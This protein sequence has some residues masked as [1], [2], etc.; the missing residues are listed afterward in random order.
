VEEKGREQENVNRHEKELNVMR[1]DEFER[2]RDVALDI[3][4]KT[5]MWRYRYRPPLLVL[6][7][8]IGVK[9]PPFLLAD[10]GIIII[11]Q[12]VPMSII[13]GL[14]YI[15]VSI[16]TGF[17]PLIL[18]LVLMTCFLYWI[19]GTIFVLLENAYLRQKYK[20]P[21]WSEL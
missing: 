7:W 12:T 3:L 16:I 21:R 19:I 18:S 11:Y 5:G 14:S 15:L 13:F 10:I 6:L 17:F 9:I 8:Y 1:E 20:L 2:K 4:A